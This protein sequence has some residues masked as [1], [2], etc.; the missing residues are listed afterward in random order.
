MIEK[1][2]RTQFTQMNAQENAKLL[3]ASVPLWDFGRVK[4]RDLY[5]EYSLVSAKAYQLNNDFPSVH[6]GLQ[7]LNL[8]LVSWM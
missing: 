5:A 7:L 8:M 2:F 1:I 3:P 6:V 4:Y